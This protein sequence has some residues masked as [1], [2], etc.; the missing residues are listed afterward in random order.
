MRKFFVFHRMKLIFRFWLYKKR[1]HT[2]WKFQV[3][4]T[5]NEKVIAKKP[6]TNLYEMNISVFFFSFTTCSIIS[7]YTDLMCYKQLGTYDYMCCVVKW[8]FLS[9]AC[10]ESLLCACFNYLCSAHALTLAA[11]KY[12]ECLQT[13]FIIIAL[14]SNLTNDGFT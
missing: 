6:L 10:H 13:V 5:S 8:W 11:S 7:N 1:W 2:S 3:E 4:K 14:W 9:I 12:D